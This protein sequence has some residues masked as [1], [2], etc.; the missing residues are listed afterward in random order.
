M[1]KL[2]IKSHSILEQDP[3]EFLDACPICG[4]AEYHLIHNR[5]AIYNDLNH[6]TTVETQLCHR[7]SV[8]FS[9]P[10]CQKR[11]SRSSISMNK[12]PYITTRI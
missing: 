10:G 5:G 1:N 7:C 6:T 11:P 9:N 12:G 2:G 3:D 8:L 4:S